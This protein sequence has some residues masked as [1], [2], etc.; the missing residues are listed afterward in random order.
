MIRTAANQAVITF[1]LCYPISFIE[2][3]FYDKVNTMRK[4]GYTQLLRFIFIRRHCYS[5][6]YRAYTL[7]I[8]LILRSYVTKVEMT[9]PHE[10]MAGLL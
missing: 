1:E 7:Y 10:D 3:S 2:L 6:W 5:G 9:T 4:L 8:A